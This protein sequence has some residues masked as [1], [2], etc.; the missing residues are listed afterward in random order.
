MLG[1]VVDTT[2]FPTIV[3]YIARGN[4]S[5]L[6]LH[7]TGRWKTFDRDGRAIAADSAIRLGMP[8]E[9]IGV[10]GD[11]SSIVRVV[12]QSPVQPPPGGMVIVRTTS[13]VRVDARGRPS[14]LPITSRDPVVMGTMRL[15]LPETPLG[16]INGATIVA[17]PNAISP[18]RITSWPV[19]PSTTSLASDSTIW[20][21]DVMLWRIVTY[22]GSGRPRVVIH[23]P[24]PPANVTAQADHPTPLDSSWM[25]LTLLDDSGRLWMEPFDMPRPDR[26]RPPAGTRPTIIPRVTAS[27]LWGFGPDG[28]LLGGMEVPAGLRVLQIG[29][30]FIFGLERREGKIAAVTYRLRPR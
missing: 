9:W 5:S 29:P 2:L 24:I 28:A 10:L 13:F 20:D 17:S 6:I 4:D 3:T 21:I 23:P 7:A 22:D 16:S 14:Y 12:D 1:R 27:R 11:G 18:P 26:D 15:S 19:R 30:D 8:G 25:L